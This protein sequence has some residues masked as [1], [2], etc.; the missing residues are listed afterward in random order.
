MWAISR[1]HWQDTL[2]YPT[3]DTEIICYSQDKHY[4]LTEAICYDETQYEE[5]CLKYE[6]KDF[7]AKY[8]YTYIL[9]DRNT[10]CYRGYGE[11]YNCLFL[12]ILDEIINKDQFIH[13][14]NLNY[15]YDNNIPDFSGQTNNEIYTNTLEKFYEKIKTVPLNELELIFNHYCQHSILD[16]PTY[17]ERYGIRYIPQYGNHTKAVK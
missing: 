6:E 13:Q 10:G 16:S 14:R 12:S 8:K 9:D 2:G 11:I 1:C 4:A 17:I 15:I 5:L 7:P 3:I